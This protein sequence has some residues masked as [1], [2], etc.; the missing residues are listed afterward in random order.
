MKYSPSPKRHT[1]HENRRRLLTSSLVL[2][3]GKNSLIQV[4]GFCIDDRGFTTRNKWF[5]FSWTHRTENRYAYC[6][7]DPLNLFDPYGHALEWLAW[8]V[9]ISVGIATTVFT[10]G[11]AAAVAGSMGASAL[12][13]SLIGATVG[14]AFGN[15]AGGFAQATYQGVTLVGGIFWL[16]SGRERSEAF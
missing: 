16:V 5:S 3:I 8:A 13:A 9:G 10:G 1:V 15:L 14:D 12:T 7:G 11:L 6:E 4:L 2:A